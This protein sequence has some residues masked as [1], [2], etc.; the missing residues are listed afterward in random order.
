MGAIVNGLAVHGGIIKPYSATFLTFSDY[1]R[2]TI[3]LGALMK[4]PALYVFTHDSIGLGEDGPDASIGRAGHVAAADPP[5][6]RLPPG[7]RQRDG[8]SVALGGGEPR[9]PPC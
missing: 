6:A 9:R 7:G 5:F 8:G 1:M 3:R 2:P 4:I